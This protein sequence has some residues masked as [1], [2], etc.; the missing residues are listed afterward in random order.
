MKKVFSLFLSLLFVFS[1]FNMN[2]INA[3]AGDNI[4]VKADNIVSKDGKYT[5]FIST[6]DKVYIEKLNFGKTFKIIDSIDGHPIYSY[7]FFDFSDKFE[8]V[9][10][11]PNCQKY[12]DKNQINFAG[13]ENIKKLVVDEGITTISECMFINCTNLNA[14]YLPSTI[15]HIEKGAFYGTNING[16]Q[17]VYYNGNEK[18]Y[19]KI[20]FDDCTLLDYY[21]SF[22]D[23]TVY[24]CLIGGMTF[25]S[26]ASAKNSIT[27][28][29]YDMKK[30][31][32]FDV[33]LSTDKNFKKI[34]KR[35]KFTNKKSLNKTFTGLKPKTKY[36]W[37]IKISYKKKGITYYSYWNDDLLGRF[38]HQPLKT[39]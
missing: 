16:K 10:L 23:K 15:K 24:N 36:Y 29:A 19:K 26:Y 3:F 5:Y 7:E 9:I 31:Y 20:K 28:R 32:T 12:I 21:V 33:Q 35:Y 34:N 8:K 14:I 17:K 25:G 4:T 13:D 6:D 27:L 1:V 38:D 18:Q 22:N 30:S 11:T 39:K 37:Q 2:C